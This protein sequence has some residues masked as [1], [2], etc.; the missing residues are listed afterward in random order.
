[1]EQK[2]ILKNQQRV[3]RHIRRAM[4]LQSEG[5]GFGGLRSWLCEKICQTSV[6]ENKRLTKWLGTPILT[7]NSEKEI[8]TR[9]DADFQLNSISGYI[10]NLGVRENKVFYGHISNIIGCFFAR[11]KNIFNDYPGS[12][13]FK[14]FIQQ[15]FRKQK[16]YELGSFKKFVTGY[17][18]IGKELIHSCLE[19]LISIKFLQ[20]SDMI[21]LFAKPVLVDR[22]GVGPNHPSIFDQ[23]KSHDV[24][25]LIAYYKKLGFTRFKETQLM[26]ASVK[27]ILDSA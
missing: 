25:K 11:A 16:Y 2:Q 27:E 18:H 14:N 8:D 15:N 10:I 5:E 17:S 13:E 21:V 26:H 22:D 9:G 24:E 19:F 1:M 12:Y 20:E 6:K 4:E 3:A 23:Q 7:E